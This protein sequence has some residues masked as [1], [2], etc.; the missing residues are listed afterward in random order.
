M[1]ICC[2]QFSYNY[3]NKCRRYGVVNLFLLFLDDTKIQLEE[4]FN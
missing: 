3:D 1:Q 4:L 2:V